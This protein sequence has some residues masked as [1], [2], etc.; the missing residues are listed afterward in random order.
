MHTLEMLGNVTGLVAFQSFLR[1]KALLAFWAFDA[2]VGY[3]KGQSSSLNTIS[4][5]LRSVAD[6]D[7]CNRCGILAKAGVAVVV[8]VSLCEENCMT[9]LTFQFPGMPFAA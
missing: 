9:I 3:I 6:H 4:S 7:I 1:C 8:T 2:A 5:R